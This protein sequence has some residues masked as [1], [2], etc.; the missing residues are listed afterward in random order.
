MLGQQVLLLAYR[1]FRRPLQTRAGRRLFLAAYHVYKRFEARDVSALAPLI[2]SGSTVIDVGANVGFFAMRFARW[3]GPGGTVIAIE[4]EAG[5]ARA[6]RSE[7]L[8]SGLANVEC[9]EAA[10]GARVGQGALGVNS[11]TPA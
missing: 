11:N 1:I 9:V 8:R 5:N 3:V 10:A 6:L 7:V 2:V 4:P